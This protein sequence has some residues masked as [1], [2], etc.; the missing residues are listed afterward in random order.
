MTL[1]L[2]LEGLLVSGEPWPSVLDYLVV[3]KN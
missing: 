3:N 2:I 1:L